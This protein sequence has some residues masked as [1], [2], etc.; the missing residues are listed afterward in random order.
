M[1]S[2]IGEIMRRTCVVVPV[3][4]ILAAAVGM[5][6]IRLC[7]LLLGEQLGLICGQ[8]LNIPC[9]IYIGSKAA[10]YQIKGRE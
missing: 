10:A 3:M 1:A 7:Q 9:G 8:L 4:V 2:G 6:L 5:I